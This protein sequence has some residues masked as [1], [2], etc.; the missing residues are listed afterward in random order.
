MVLKKCR[1]CFQ[2]K[3][4]QIFA[5]CLLL[6]AAGAA[7]EGHKAVSAKSPGSSCLLCKNY[8]RL[9]IKT[10]YLYLSIISDE[11]KGFVSGVFLHILAPLYLR[12]G[13]RIHTKFV[14]IQVDVVNSDCC[15]S[16]I[17][18]RTFIA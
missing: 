10:I 18:L 16:M 12:C 7:P 1:N 17:G 4:K 14:S 5:F 9:E 15:K 13:T 6:H 11:K 3:R 2:L 8:Y